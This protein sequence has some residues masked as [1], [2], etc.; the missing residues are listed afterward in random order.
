MIEVKVH[1]PAGT[2]V[3]NRPEQRNALTRNML[4]ELKDALGDLHGQKN[5]RAVVLTG[6]GEVFCSGMDLAEKLA[7]CRTD[8]PLP[9]WHSDAVAYRELIDT[10][11]RFPKPIIAAVNGD[12][13]CGGA[14]LVLASDIVIAS[15][16]AQFGLTDP[17]HGLVS[18]M[19]A[20]LLLFRIGGAWASRLMLTASPIDAQ[21]SLSLGIF[22]EMVE[23]DLLW[24]RAVELARTIAQCAPESLQLTKRMLNETAGEQLSMLLSAGAAVTATSHTTAAASEGISAAVDGREPE[25]K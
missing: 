15:P 21:Q 17:R 2:I 24:A 14:G 20:P 22:Q 16:A 25:W 8:D 12:A 7:T 6:A 18:G 9:V 3:I 1:A 4:F 11:L 13:L 19:I 23:H 5:V 10:M